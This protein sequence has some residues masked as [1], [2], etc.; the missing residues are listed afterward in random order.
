[1]VFRLDKSAFAYYSDK[2]HD[3][4]SETGEYN[5]LI[6]ESS[7]SVCLEE[8][9]HYNADKNLPV[10]F[11]LDNPNGDISAV[12]EGKQLFEELFKSIDIGTN[13]GADA[14]GESGALMALAMADDLP[15][16]AMISFCD[17]EEIT[18]EKLKALIDRLNE[19]LEEQ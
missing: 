16:H 7:A 9:V 4:Y 15:V 19:M 3:W 2:I 5:I 13:G 11:T 14:L 10:H 8:T 12:P 18:R 1:V 17:R 6:A